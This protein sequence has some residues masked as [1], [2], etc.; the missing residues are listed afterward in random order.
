VECGRCGVRMTTR[1]T[2]RG[3]RRY[4]C[5]RQRGGCDRCG[6]AAPELEQLV[7]AMVIEA[8]DGNHLAALLAVDD[9]DA[10][11]Q[12]LTALTE[13]DAALE[14]LSRDYYVDR[15][16]SRVEF[17]AARQPLEQ[18][19]DQLRRRLASIER[20][21]PLRTY[22]TANQPLRD[23]WRDLSFSQQ[24]AVLCEIVSRVEISPTMRANNRFDADRVT[25]HWRV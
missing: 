16:I 20:S 15:F 14:Q 7:I 12:A 5:S 9:N 4:V 8:V 6:C 22:V 23:R 10:E 25:V 18:R 17:A 19:A 1:P 3:K 13:V 2:E 21:H 24:R 11:T